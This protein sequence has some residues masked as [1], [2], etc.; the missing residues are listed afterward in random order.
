VSAGPTVRVLVPVGMLG[1][2]FPPDSVRR[3]S[4]LGADVIAVDA[5]STD[6]GPYYLGA[7]VAKT[8]RA[9]V[10]RDLRLI[11]L[12]ARD[13]GIPV[14]VGSCGTSGTDSGVDWVADIAREIARGEQLA[15]TVARIYSEQD[16]E[17]V[18]PLLEAG[19]IRPLPPA[20]QLDPDT[21]R[22]CSHIVGVLGHEPIAA[23]LDAGANL[24][25]AGRATDTALIAA[26][27]LMRGLP[28]GPAW[29]GAKIAEC[30]GLCTTDPR[31]AG[32][33]V[34]FDRDGFT[35]EPLDPAAA[36]TPLT[37]A[38]HMMYE[39]R[40]PFRMREPGG[41]LDATDARY[42]ALDPRSVRVEGS[43]FE[44]AGQYTTKLEGAAPAG[45]QTTILVGIADPHVLANVDGFR[46]HVLNYL[47]KGVTRD[48]GLPPREFDLQLRAYG[49][50]ALLPAGAPAPAT[51]PA[52]VGLLFATTAADQATATQIAKYANP[53]LLHAPLPGATSLPS[54]AFASSPAETERGQIYQFTLCHA[55][56][57][58]AP[59]QLFR[60]EREEIGR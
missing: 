59:D 55:V 48:L 27:P 54:Y 2:G 37:V 6:S 51:P 41:T 3:A 60:S 21:L 42:T 45:W 16:P 47:A 4:E 40:D 24:I 43:A 38:A 31:G 5:G 58:D 19:R 52:E 12:A 17:A 8:A 22:R 49:H 50:S 44:P 23:A 7:G 26:V 39:N 1:G 25:L 9:A 30:G 32:V 36:C 14:I 53:V 18:L 13:A 46:R 56:D 35:V 33:L 29:H 34:S 57:V 20:G 28:A 15:L 10:A 11:L